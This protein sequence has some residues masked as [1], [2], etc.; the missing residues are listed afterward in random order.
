MKFKA[1][2]TLVELLVVIAIIAILAAILLPALAN[3]KG[4]AKTAH[5]AA[6]M[7]QL[8]VTPILFTDD[9]NGYLPLVGYFRKNPAYQKELFPPDSEHLPGSGGGFINETWVERLPDHNTYWQYYE[10]YH[11]QLCTAHPNQKLFREKIAANLNSWQLTNTYL[12]PK[13][14]FSSWSQSNK[15]KRKLTYIQNPNQMFMC[16]EREDYDSAQKGTNN[17]ADSTFSRGWGTYQYKTMGY[18]HNNYNG[19]NAGFFDGH[20]RFYQFNHQPISGSDG[21][22]INENWDQ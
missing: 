11:D 14:Y 10:P 2:F 21:E 20:I 7:K 12:Y 18:H 5:C 22:L 17:F 6:I 8:L 4:Y 13:Y 19:F 9:Y 15:W 16:L 3:A 1:H